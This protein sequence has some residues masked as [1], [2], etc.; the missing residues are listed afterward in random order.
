MHTTASDGRFTPAELAAAAQA[1]GLSVIT[2]ADHDRVVNV[3]PLQDEAAKLGIHVIPAVEISC[4]WDDV[5]YHLLVYN[6]DLSNPRLL[7]PLEEMSSKYADICTSG[8]EEL[9]KQGK[10]LDPAVLQLCHKGQPV[11]PY[12]VF[13]AL[14][15]HEYAPNMKE[16]HEMAKTVGVDFLPQQE[17]REVINAARETGAVPVLAHPARAEPGFNPPSEDTLNAM[18]EAGLM[19]FEVWHPYHSSYDVAYYLKLCTD[20]GLL[21]STGSDTHAPNDHRRKLTKWP[22]RYSQKLLEVCGITIAQ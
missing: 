1:Q 6:V 7:G 13:Q 22:A 4:K 11:A 19:G 9:A 8:I 16:A 20:R 5:Q 17:M 15:K 14:I 3:R 18:I 10:Y 2:L 12:H 21:M